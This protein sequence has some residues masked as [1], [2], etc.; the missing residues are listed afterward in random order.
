MNKI[1]EEEL[2]KIQDQQ[3]LL[4][5]ILHEIGIL[6]SSKHALLHKI[7]GVN[8]E[9]EELKNE[10]EKEYGPVNINVDDGSYTAIEPEVTEVE[11]V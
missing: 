1:I 4:N 5:A 7:A 8:E 3:T 10:L 9:V 6:E 11:N 2:T